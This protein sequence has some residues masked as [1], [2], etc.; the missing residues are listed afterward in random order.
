MHRIFDAAMKWSG[1]GIGP[2]IHF[3]NLDTSNFYIVF[4]A[5]DHVIDTEV[6]D[7]ELEAIFKDMPNAKEMITT[8]VKNLHTLGYGHGDITAGGIGIK[9]GRVYI[10]NPD[11]AYKISDGWNE[12]WLRDWAIDGYR[13]TTFNDN[14]FD[15]FVFR[16]FENA[17][18]QPYFN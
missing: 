10:L 13:I 16:D 15:E 3:Y 1:A 12:A 2:T 4:E 8:A 18:W 11:Y 6:G 9:N 14:T 7:E 5:M 17:M